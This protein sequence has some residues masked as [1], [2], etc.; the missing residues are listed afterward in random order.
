[1]FQGVVFDLK[2]AVRLLRR[3]PR[4]TSIA[5]IILAFGIGANTAMFSAINHVLLRPLPFPDA[6][7]L[8]RLRDAMSSA[9]GELHAFNMRARS[10][11]AIQAETTLFD[12]VAA[13]SGENMT[14]AGPDLPERVSVV[15]EAPGSSSAIGVW[16]VIGRGFTPEEERSGLESGVALVS[17]PFWQT[18]FGGSRSA[19]GTAVRLDGRQFTIVGVMPPQYAFPYEAQFWVPFG[20]NPEDRSRDFAVFARLA[21]GVTVEQARRALQVTAGEMR[22]RYADVSPTY[23]IEV[24]TVRQNLVGLQ[25][26]PLRALTEV[27]AVLLLIAGINVATMLLARAVGRRREFAVRAALG[28]GRGRHVCQLLIESAVLAAAGCSAGLLLTSWFAPLTSALI[29]PVLSGQLGLTTPRIDMR[30]LGFAVVSSVLSALVAGLVPALGSWTRRPQ[31]VLADASRGMTAGPAAQRLLGALVVAETALTLVLLA[32]AGLIVRNFVRLQS[33]PLGFAANELLTM[34]IMPPFDRYPYGPSRAALVDRLV[35]AIAAEPGVAA[36]AATTVN[37]LGG[38]TWAAPVITEDAARRDPNATYNVNHR[39]VTPALFEA[40]RIPLLRGRAF[41]SADGPS[42]LPAVIV[43]DRLARRFWPGE[44]AVGKRIRIARPDTPWSTV[45]GI[46]GDVSDSHDPGVPFETWYLPLEQHA[47]SPAAE[48]FNLMVRAAGDPLALVPA[49]RRAVA[50]VDR[51]LAPYNPAALDAY[52]SDA[53]TRERVSARLM[54][55]FGAFG[56]ALAALGV[57]GVMAFTI[58]QRTAEI[59]IR[60]ALGAHAADIVPLVL[61]RSGWLVTAGLV[62][63]AF[64]AL[65]VNRMLAGLLTEVGPLDPAVLASACALTLSAAALACVVPALRAARL[66]PVRALKGGPQ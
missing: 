21:P 11:L 40:M 6:D 37:P 12:G 26:A 4:T 54:L 49:V 29:P 15:S 18:R 7:R 1:M 44:D 66:D 45:V 53:L 38:G 62:V 57:Y 50:R 3:S 20:L 16:P 61:G 9:D 36:A 59:G 5:V 46:V 48:K 41:S 52:Y 2:H 31:S 51:T 28:A 19:L 14:L 8:I 56:L 58:A 64:A 63:G 65:A 25:D 17:H 32:G 10:V 33:M 43:S 39:L 42:A 60:M 22:R 23:S 13:F 27:V 30:V 24:M 34:E 55:V 47:A 35:S